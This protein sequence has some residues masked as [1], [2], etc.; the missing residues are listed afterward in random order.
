M[1]ASTWFCAC[2]DSDLWTKM[3]SP[4]LDAV[5]IAATAMTKDIVSRARTESFFRWAITAF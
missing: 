3:K 4:K 5:K 2:E 1:A